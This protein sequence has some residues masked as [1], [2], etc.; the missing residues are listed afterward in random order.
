MIRINK[1]RTKVICVFDED[2]GGLID[3][4]RPSDSKYQIYLKLYN[5][6]KNKNKYYG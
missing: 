1:L 5:N 2:E 4:Y 3:V 6:N